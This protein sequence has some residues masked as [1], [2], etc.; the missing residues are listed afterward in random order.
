MFRLRHE[1]WGKLAANVPRCPRSP[2][3]T[4]QTSAPYPPKPRWPPA[5]LASAIPRNTQREKWSRWLRGKWTARPGYLPL[6]PAPTMKMLAWP[7]VVCPL[8]VARPELDRQWLAGDVLDPH[9]SAPHPFH[10][11]QHF[12]EEVHDR[13]GRLKVGDYAEDD[14]VFQSHASQAAAK[15]REHRPPDCLAG[16]VAAWRLLTPASPLSR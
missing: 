15:L 13:R 14:S 1:V 6:P 10:A 7:E 11:G 9:V 4:D 8:V 16:R 12:L 2:C 5:I 3:V